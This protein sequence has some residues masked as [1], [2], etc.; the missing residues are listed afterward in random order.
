[1]DVFSA[2]QT[3]VSG[4]KAQSFSLSNIS[5]NI[6]NSQT[7]GYKRIDTSFVD[8]LVDGDAKSQTAG[9]VGAF[10]ELTNSIQGNKV[11]TGVSTNMAIDGQGFFAVRKK[12]TDA[13]GGE[14]FTAGNLYTRRGDFAPDKDGYLV[15]TAGAYLV[16]AS[17]D[18]VTGQ[19]NGT[20]PI[21][22][23]N[24]V[25]PAKP[26]TT[27]T[28]SAN[29]P[30]SPATTN[31]ASTQGLLSAFSDGTDARVTP[32]NGAT[33]GSVSQT[34][35]QSFI[36]NSIAGPALTVYT[37]SGAPVSVQSRWAKVAAADTAAGTSDT[38]NLFTADKTSVNGNQASWTNIG[39]A[40]TFSPSGQMTAPTGKTVPISNLT[41]DGVNVG[42]VT[43]DL[44]GGLTQYA[45]A[46]GTVTT[47]DLKQNGY[48]S[49]TLNSVEVGENG[50][51]SGKYSNGSV[52]GLARVEVAQFVNPDGLKPDSLGNYQQTVASGEP[53]VGLKDSTVVGANV[54]QSNTDIAAEFSKMIVTQQAYSANTR[55]MSTAQ[56]MIS[57][58]LNVIR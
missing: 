58:L 29:L 47:N 43:L 6:A 30:K 48:A 1:M 20:G 22:I 13:G 39:Q 18:P 14:G 19:T 36:D 56:T 50:I 17:L 21:K 12:T 45:A 2:L 34:N 53:I 54:E 15:N 27:I 44:S 5:G 26:T 55:V 52:I 51:I 3:A 9:S 31:A 41:V 32:A 42:E 23:S 25:I 40:F 46:S 49:G 28:Y 11:S 10:S 16:G 7:T 24:A 4:L 57:D 33:T 38:W 35:A 37:A 8:M